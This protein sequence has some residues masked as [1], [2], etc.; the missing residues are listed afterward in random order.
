MTTET[1]LRLGM[2]I[3]VLLLLWTTVM[4]NNDIT[5]IKS[6]KNTIDDL[7]KSFDSVLYL[8]DSLYDENFIKSVELGRDELT[9]EYV[10]E[11]FPSVYN[12]AMNFRSHE[13]E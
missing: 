13:T 8:K 4:W 11:K 9:W 1:K 2:V 3:S 12:N 5:T 10:K 7:N 6:Q